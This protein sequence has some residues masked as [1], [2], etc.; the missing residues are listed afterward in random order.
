MTRDH[1]RVDECWATEVRIANGGHH[2]GV[3]L[4][5]SAE[6]DSG[7]IVLQAVTGKSVWGLAWSWFT[8]LFK[9]SAKAQ[10][11]TEWRG[12]R[13]DLDARPRQKISVDGEVAAET[14]VTIEVARAA[15]DVAAPRESTEA[16][17][18]A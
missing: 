12:R 6:L 5:E 7:E 18:S 2:G 3:E 17:R 8:T 15:I 9:L 16:S 1:G 13:L 11:V 4:V 14:P 10:T